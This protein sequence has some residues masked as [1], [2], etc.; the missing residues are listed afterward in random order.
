MIY[1]FTDYEALD[2]ADI[3]KLYNALPDFRKKRTDD[4]KFSSGKRACI[5]SYFVFLYG[6]RKATG[7]TDM[8][9][10]CYSDNKKPYL[11]DISQFHFNISH[12][13]TAIA[14]ICHDFPAGIDIECVRTYNP[15]ITEKVCSK[16]EINTINSSSNRAEAFCKIW[17]VKEAI[18]K[19][20]GCGITVDL[21]KITS[22]T[23]YSKTFQ[24]DNNTFMSYSVKEN[25]IAQPIVF[26][27][28][29]ELFSLI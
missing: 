19:T 1:L 9:E 22:D 29:D 23:A 24:I 14:C 28:I 18:T 3:N 6:Y 11:R 25:K 2:E 21:T 8:P 12:C 15:R 5:I 27:T 13:K 20:D 4:F 16:K 10:F 17:T 7:N 26:L